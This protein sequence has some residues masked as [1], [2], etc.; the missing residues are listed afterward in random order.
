MQSDVR[1]GRSALSNIRQF[2]A[3][4]KI[5]IFAA[6]TS[7]HVEGFT[8]AVSLP[9]GT[10]TLLL[11]EV[12]PIFFCYVTLVGNCINPLL[13]NPFKNVSAMQETKFE[14]HFLGVMILETGESYIREVLAA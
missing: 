7:H 6:R 5:Y 8:R 2:A 4:T 3:A 11:I 12:T 1:S 14:A 13:L 10:R 9:R